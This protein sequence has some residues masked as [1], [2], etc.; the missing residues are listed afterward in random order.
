MSMRKISERLHFKQKVSI[1]LTCLLLLIVGIS[2]ILGAN[3]AGRLFSN[4][5]FI[6]RGFSAEY[7]ASATDK[8]EKGLLFSGKS[9]ASVSL[10]K[11][12]S[13]DFDMGFCALIKQ[14]TLTFDDGNKDIS[15]LFRRDENALSLSIGDE[16]ST[17]VSVPTFK[18]SVLLSADNKQLTVSTESGNVSFKTEGFSFSS[19]SVQLSAEENL[20]KS[21]KLYIYSVNGVSLSKPIIH[22]APS[23]LYIAI[24]SDGVQGEAYQIPAPSVYNVIDGASS[25][26]RVSVQKGA[27]TLLPEQAW[28]KGLSFN[29]D[30]TGEYT[31]SIYAGDKD[32][33]LEKS[34]IVNVQKT[35]NKSEISVKA[36]F[37][38]AKVGKGSC[39]SLPTVRFGNNL[40]KEYWQQTQYTVSLNGKVITSKVGTE[41]GAMFTFD[42]T[43]TYTFN[44]YSAV[45]YLHDEYSF[46]V[47]VTDSLPAIRFA[48]NDTDRIVGDAFVLPTVELKQDGK[49]LK[50]QTVL[51]FPSGKAVVNNTT[52]TEEGVYTLEFRT[53]Q[54]NKLCQ[55]AYDF[56]VT[57]RLH[58][59]SSDAEYGSWTE[60]YFDSPVDGLLVELANGESYE[61][62]NILD[63]SD[64][65]GDNVDFMKFYLLPFEKGSADFTGMTITLTDAYD[66][67]KYV[68]I[69]F[70]VD[71]E[72]YG[73]AYVKA[74]AYNQ[75][76]LIGLQWWTKDR[77]SIHRNNQYGYTGRLSFT[78]DDNINYPGG[79]ANL[80]FNLGFDNETQYLYGTHGWDSANII[81][82]LNRIITRLADNT[83]YKEA[84][85][86]FT[87]GEVRMSISGL[88]YKSSKGRILI[89][90][91][92]GQDLRQTVVQDRKG[93]MITV[94]CGDYSVDAV[95]CAVVGKQYPLFPA[96]AKDARSGN[97]PVVC[98]VSMVG[99][100]HN[101][102]VNCKDNVFTPERTGTYLITYTASD[103]FKNTTT[104]TITV[105]AVKEAAMN[106]SL[107][108][109]V[110]E[111]LCGQIVPIAGYTCTGGSGTPTLK[112]VTV[113]DPT[114]AEIMLTDGTF[115]PE[116][117]GAYRVVYEFVD[118]IGQT[119]SLE[120]NVNVTI[121]K[122]P[123]LNVDPTLPMAFIDGGAYKLP[124]ISAAD[125]S[126]GT[127]R[128]VAPEIYVTDAAG[129]NQIKNGEYTASGNNGAKALVSYVFKTENG[130]TVKE[131]SV[132]LR[133]LSVG[134][135]KDKLFNVA[136]LIVP[137]NGK[138][139]T[140]NGNDNYFLS[141]ASD[142]TF[143]FANP[144]LANVFSFEFNVGFTDKG[145]VTGSDLN[146]LR[147]KLIDTENR[148][149]QIMI[150]IE[151]NPENETT[152]LISVNG[153]TK[154]VLNGTFKRNTNYPFNIQYNGTTK[155]VVAGD[156]INIGVDTF[157]NGSEFTGFSSGKAYCQVE[158]IGVGK[159]GALIELSSVNGQPLTS[160]NM[161]DRISPSFSMTQPIKICYS[162]SDKL[163]LSR[164]L[165]SD[166]LSLTSSVRVS[167]QS[168]SGETVT[169]ADGTKLDMAESKDYEVVLSKTGTY[170]LTF[171]VW[172]D[173]GGSSRAIVQSLNVFGKQAPEVKPS[174]NSMSARAGETVDAKKLFKVNDKDGEA[175]LEVYYF[176][177]N[178][179]GKLTAADSEGR[180]RFDDSGSCQ[181]LCVAY[182]AEGNASR[183]SIQVNVGGAK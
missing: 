162:V 22:Q 16:Q 37:P 144:L 67:S 94:D 160:A 149:Q 122:N 173:N 111:A 169:A 108:D 79:Y 47:E 97:A 126:T 43:G 42:E 130:Q 139:V 138:L 107:K 80:Y 65:T 181:L 55:Y 90:E 106:A 3:A 9:P 62:G 89:A 77:V 177:M 150:E 45:P 105:K 8:G 11:N 137:K 132:P 147:I 29:T 112:S 133:K 117:A 52:L 95:P 116:K 48:R 64:N 182:D 179:A 14:W 152:S 161:K 114:G 146:K 104:R 76:D 158:L 51:H 178:S 27:E 50:C 121:S 85:P 136:G 84:F 23:R 119:T 44:Y 115:L 46:S 154:Y 2:P 134:D 36:A 33:A 103:F 124:T 13:G 171:T 66:A 70:V 102:D 96:T 81:G 41:M 168:P 39:V 17:L 123:I 75:N 153:G 113:T 68:L 100:K 151:P 141:T 166:V 174:K 32:T 145:V 74:R 61:F 127:K 56:E 35:A 128:E 180:V 155:C 159:G 120:Y 87:T 20:D 1:G 142:E 69:D 15:V 63:L 58:I 156:G 38:F 6:A 53:M 7:S 88:N 10:R 167:L 183:A 110:K 26:V 170:L 86:G 72:N 140:K 118:Y 59:T 25:D 30:T 109:P 4:E 164:V 99:E 18:I 148:N 163:H 172:D 28:K 176:V 165:V 157:A 83:L 49:D 54:D 82:S 78:G 24:D 175:A 19:Y 91:L 98:K 60:G 40:Y 131:Y 57:S 71:N 93:P 34:Y 31:I 92:D 73:E 5:L 135:K 125:Y 12:V 129:K 21:A 101:Y 143:F